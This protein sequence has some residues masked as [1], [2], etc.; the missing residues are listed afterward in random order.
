[1]SDTLEKLQRE[2]EATQRA[3]AEDEA[4]YAR[5]DAKYKAIVKELEDRCKI[6]EH[7]HK[8]WETALDVVED[9]IFLHDKDF[10][11]LRCN[12]A[13]QQCAEIPFEQIIG[14]PYYNVFPKNQ[15]PMHRCRRAIENAAAGVCVDEEVS[16]GDKI[17]NSRDFSIT[18]GQGDYLYS[19]HILEDI[20]AHKHAEKMLIASNDLLRTVVEN[21]PI[22]VF[23]KDTE[24][25]YLGCN[26][27][28]ARDA[29]MSRPQDLLGKDDFQMGW[30]EQAELYSADDKHVMDSGTPKLSYEEPQAT[31]DG[32]TI[33]LR[34]SKVP[35]RAADGKVFGMLGI[36]EDITESKKA[37]AELR[38]L[39]LVLKTL[40]EADQVLLHA[41]AESE[42]A[43]N[44]CNVIIANRGYALALIGLVRHDENKRIDVVAIAGDGKGYV[45]SLQLS[46]DDRLSGQGPGGIA[47]RTGQTQIM[48]D[49]RNDPHYEPWREMAVKYHFA[50]SIALP[51]KENGETFGI[52]GIYANEASAFG[53]SEVALLEEV[54]NDLAFGIVNLRTRVERDHAVQGRQHYMERL[55]ASLEEALQAIAL[56]VEMRD[57][58]TAEVQYAVQ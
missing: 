58:Y 25:R 24:L 8:E 20:T 4:R 14:Q 9:P 41:S 23:W 11:V 55:R 43:Q 33:W 36:Y 46:W 12:R 31:P 52:L 16:V 40:V 30:R 27:A 2:L 39:N 51:L 21:T 7:A 13:Y 28:F 57:P 17:Y 56:T 32:R 34:T 47:V 42:L 48:H 45:D 6:L 5:Q 3:L 37:E 49:I 18:D 10:H 1:M 44:I 15:E 19:V 38:R 53:A 22:R 50:S 29:G 26:T 54:A 35:L